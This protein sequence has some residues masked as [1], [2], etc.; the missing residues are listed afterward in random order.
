MDFCPNYV[1]ELG[2][3]SFDQ[4]TG[5]PGDGKVP[6]GPGGGEGTRQLE[7]THTGQP[8]QILHFQS[9]SLGS[10]SDIAF[11]S[12]KHSNGSGMMLLSGRQLA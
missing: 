10:D 4:E 5:E 1:Q 12:E 8:T 6:V 3:L 9:P 11:A 2:L 7:Q